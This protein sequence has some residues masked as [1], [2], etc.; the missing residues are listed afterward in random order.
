MRKIALLLAIF[1]LGL[2]VF[3][4]APAQATLLRTWVSGSGADSGTCAHAAPCFTFGYALT[5]TTPGGEINCV[6]AGNYGAMTITFA[7]TISC[8]AGTAGIAA[9]GPNTAI[10]VNAAVTD[11]VTLR[12]LDINGL[13]TG[14]IGIFVGQAK[15][16]HIEN[17]AMRGFH[18]FGS[19]AGI[20]VSTQNT[21]NTV[22]IYVTDS[23]ISGNNFGVILFNGG[24]FKVASLKNVT[25]TGS[26][27]DGVLAFNTDIFVNITE[28]VI[29]GNGGSAVKVGA[30]SSFANVDRT[31]MANNAVALNAAVS[32]ATIRAVGNNIFDNT[33]AFS[34]AVGATIASDGQN[35]TGG[36]VGGQN[37]NA[38]LTLK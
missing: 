14:N 34:F 22:F 38:S 12:G 1:G 32:G 8:E 26:T 16:V 13:G 30:P 31:T 2:P 37:A 23:V 24:G 36:N 10:S 27:S 29:S 5:Q 21:A 25:I 18:F 20:S 19:S 7:V 6:D 28:S 15:T 3:A 35:R 17:C 9:G 4:T 11:D 33:T